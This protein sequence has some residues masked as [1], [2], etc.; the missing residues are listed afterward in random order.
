MP[1]FGWI[2]MLYMK[3]V[4]R[5]YKAKTKLTRR[6]P[7]HGSPETSIGPSLTPLFGIL[8]QHEFAAPRRTT[9]IRFGRGD[10]S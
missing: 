10:L 4:N 9:A 8:K 6:N 7:L 1:P 2:E 5:H 3:N